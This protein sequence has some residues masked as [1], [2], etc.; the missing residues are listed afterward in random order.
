[1]V[2]KGSRSNLICCIFFVQSKL[3]ISVFHL[4]AHNDETLLQIG[5]LI[6]SEVKI[7]LRQPFLL[8]GFT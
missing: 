5:V 6:D 7:S 1:M 2:Q 8:T 3:R 4:F